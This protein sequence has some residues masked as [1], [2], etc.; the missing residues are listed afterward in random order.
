MLGL[1]AAVLLI[2]GLLLPAVDQAVLAGTLGFPVGAAF[3]V[4]CI[5][6]VVAWLG[7]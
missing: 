4:L 7:P 2:L 5:Y 1:A 6:R 3:A